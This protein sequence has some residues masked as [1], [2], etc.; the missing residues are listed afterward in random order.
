MQN[1]SF[2]HVDDFLEYLPEDELKIVMKLRSLVLDCIPDCIEKL[3]YNVP[4]YQRYS[5]ICFIWPSSITW[6]GA[7]K[8]KHVRMGFTK[9][10]LLTDTGYLDKGTRKEVYWKDFT[11]MQEIDI[12][13]LRALLFEAVL[14]DEQT[15]K[16][17]TRR[18]PK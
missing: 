6:G 1:V 11:T 17:Q 9:G 7:M 12:N 14:V 8:R 3:N 13:Q 5:N 16:N 18:K 15:A 4:Y 2:R 10:Y